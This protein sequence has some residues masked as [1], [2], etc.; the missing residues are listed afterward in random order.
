[1][2]LIKLFDIWGKKGEW[3]Y[4]YGMNL[5]VVISIILHAELVFKYA[6]RDYHIEDL[7]TIEDG[8]YFNKPF[9]QKTFQDK[10]FEVSYITNHSGYRIGQEM[11]DNDTV[12]KANWLF[13]GDSYTQG[14]QVEFENLYTTHLYKSFPDQIVINAGISGFGI[15]EEYNYYIDHGQ[16]LGPEKV[17]LQLCNF[18]D[19]MQIRPK[20]RRLSDY[21]MHWSDLAR[22]LL[23]DLKYLSPGELPLGRWVEP[24]YQTKEENELYNIFYKGTSPQKREDIRN[25]KE[26]L[27]LFKKAVES[28]GAELIVIL[29]PTKEQTRFRYLEE[30]V[31]EFGLDINELDMMYPNSLMHQWTDSLDI[32][33]IDLYEEF[34]VSEQEVFFDYDEHLN[35]HGH[36]TMAGR[37][38]EQIGETKDNPTL[39]SN[40]F[41]GDRYP[42]AVQ[43]S[44]GKKQVLFQSFRDGNMELF[45]ADSS[46]TNVIR[47]TRNNVSESHPCL[48]PDGNSIIFTEGDQ[49][50]LQSKIGFFH[51]DGTHREL[52]TKEK[53]QFGAIPAYS[54]SGESIAYASWT[55]DSERDTY[56]VSSLEL[57]NLKTGTK[58]IISDGQSEY[59]RPIWT[60]DGN[61][62]IYIRKET[63]N[64]DIFHYD[65]SSDQ[66]SQLTNTPYDEWDPQVS[67]NGELMVYAARKNDNWDLYLM[68]LKSMNTQQ[69]T[70]SSGDEWDPTFYF[71]DST[72]IY[73]GVF[74][75]FNGIYRMG[76]GKAT[77]NP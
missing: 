1:M 3:I 70:E 24:F 10:E 21:L 44:S 35:E 25:L 28:N 57:I 55:F 50:T 72:I 29:I 15:A 67:P 76:I 53:H 73:A 68:E 23:Y 13:I 40:G 31:N 60:S 6:F 4:V 45:L 34:S 61:G 77:Q 56:T 65:L 37:I 42:S 39:L 74:G 62:L 18:N 11:K 48:S 38:A 75:Y 19:F 17:F 32:S 14:A 63:S 71:N 52:I 51:L 54:P 30:V 58:K 46:M 8:Y 43:S 12:K 49:S 36:W 26:Y 22:F 27:A 16:C 64:F 69:L 7:Y 33:L 2:I 41:Y 59:W 20:E 5:L 47:L 66:E 9:L